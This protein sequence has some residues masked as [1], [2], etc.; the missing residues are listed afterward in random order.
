MNEHNNNTKRR[1]LG[2]VVKSDRRLYIEQQQHISIARVHLVLL[3]ACL[4][5]IST[6][7]K[8]SF[9]EEIC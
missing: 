9:W 8:R 5:H 2:S 7:P 1:Q 6:A 4:E 3:P